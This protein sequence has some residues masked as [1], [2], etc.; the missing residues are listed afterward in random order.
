M[1]DHYPDPLAVIKGNGHVANAWCAVKYLAWH[2]AWFAFVALASVIVG[3]VGALW[4]V[5]TRIPASSI[6]RPQAWENLKAW[7]GQHEDEVLVAIVAF[8][9]GAFFGHDPLAA[10]LAPVIFAVVAGVVLGVMTALFAALEWVYDHWPRETADSIRDK[11]VAR[12][13][14]GYCPVK[15]TM[16]PKWAE[17]MWWL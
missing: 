16:K 2:T 8:G 7:V 12:R 5:G 3:F 9:Y 13:V 6:P 14:Y 17:R 11:P 10:V 1:T 4:W 15:L